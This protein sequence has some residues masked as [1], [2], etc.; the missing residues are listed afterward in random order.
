MLTAQETQ[1]LIEEFKRY[2]NKDRH[3]LPFTIWLSRKKKID[4]DELTIEE[5]IHA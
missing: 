2:C 4:I 5:N 3:P 1:E